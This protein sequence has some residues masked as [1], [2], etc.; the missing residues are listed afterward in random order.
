MGGGQS[1]TG[2]QT[3]GQNQQSQQQFDQ[4]LIMQQMLAQIQQSQA[5]SQIGIPPS[6]MQSMYGSGPQASYDPW[7]YGGGGGYG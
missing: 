2:G 5:G 6:Q 7:S 4:N 1:L 3:T